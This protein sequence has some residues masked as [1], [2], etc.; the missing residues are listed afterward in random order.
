MKTEGLQRGNNN[1]KHMHDQKGSVGG[2]GQG[3]DI[4]AATSGYATGPRGEGIK[5]SKA[6]AENRTIVT[7]RRLDA[8]TGDA[9][10]R[11]TTTYRKDKVRRAEPR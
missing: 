6:V 3:Q 10:G 7:V 5:L 8:G 4:I 11:P 1:Y 2:W 9:L